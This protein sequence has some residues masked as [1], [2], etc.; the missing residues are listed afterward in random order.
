MKEIYLHVKIK[1]NEYTAANSSAHHTRTRHKQFIKK[2][3][4]INCQEK[5]PVTSPHTYTQRDGF[6]F[7]FE[8]NRI[9]YI[10]IYMLN[11]KRAPAC[12][13]QPEI[14]LWK[15]LFQCFFSTDLFFS[16][17]TCADFSSFFFWHFVW[18][19]MWILINFYSFV[20]H[21]A[22][23]INLCINCRL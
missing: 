18:R 21:S 5:R 2:S 11:G 20:S 3:K 19:W 7:Q 4:V 22:A 8:S 6:Y 10:Y 12:H 23:E 16:F 15:W 9:K 1:I 17:S 13:C 14:I